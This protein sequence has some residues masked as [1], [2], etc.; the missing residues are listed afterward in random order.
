[1]NKNNISV[2]ENA[3]NQIRKLKVAQGN[4]RLN[5]RLSVQTGGCSGFSY[6]FALEEGVG[7]DDI[8][9]DAHGVAVIVDAASMD[10]LAGCVLDY[11]TDL[12]GSAFVVNNPNATS[13]CGCGTSFAA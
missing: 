6:V 9:I 13:T 5:L 12:M 2:T 10:L 3:A 7:T 1:M 8:A 4:E 11:K